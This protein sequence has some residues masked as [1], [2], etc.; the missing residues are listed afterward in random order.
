MHRPLISAILLMIACAQAVHATPSLVVD[1]DSRAVLQE[2]DA[3]HPWYPASTTKLMSALVTFEALAAKEVEL[4][5]PVILSHKAMKQPYAR[6]GLKV[7]SAMTL[8][9]ALYAVLVSSANEVAVAMAETVAGSEEAFVARMNATAK[10]LGLSATRFFNANGLFDPVQTVSARDLAVLAI[11]IFESYPQFHPVFET[12]FVEI[13]GKKLESRNDLLTRFPGTLGMKTGFVCSSGRNFVGLAGR[14]GRRVMVVILGA[15][16]DLE[17]SERAAKLLSE[18]FD[19]QLQATGQTVDGL[20]NAPDTPP[21]DMRLRLC[22]PQSAAYEADQ[23]RLYPMGLPGQNSYL[24]ATI[25][26][27][28]HVIQTW[29]VPQPEFVPVPGL[30]PI[31][32]AARDAGSRKSG[33]WGSVTPIPKP[34]LKAE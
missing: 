1:L 24:T 25:P 33:S 15:T 32:V 5:T 29:F 6:A 17:R 10:R 8:E 16:T 20:V 18:T 2:N 27:K 34:G 9:D 31:Q 4:S 11:E 14:D 19:G 12:F 22:S 28:G 21:E 26:P 23:N 7:G 30:K 13:N 3:G